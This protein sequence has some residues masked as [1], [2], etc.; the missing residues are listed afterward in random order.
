MDG[1]EIYIPLAGLI[2]LEKERDRIQKE[3]D[4]LQGFLKSIEGK[5]GN[6]GF[7]ENAPEAVVEKERQKK[8]DA[9]TDLSKLKKQLEEFAG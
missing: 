1:T 3:I 8:A 2:D 6:K 7:V 5:L 9:E 4:R